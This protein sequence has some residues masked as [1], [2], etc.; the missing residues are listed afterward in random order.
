MTTLETYVR[1]RQGKIW[2]RKDIEYVLGRC[3]E[4]ADVAIRL[5]RAN[6]IVSHE[7]D[8]QPTANPD[9]AAGHAYQEKP[10][11]VNLPLTSGQSAGSCPP[12]SPAR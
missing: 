8:A 6:G 4:I 11:R 12:D 7:M 1:S 9:R 5:M 2:R 10:R 3:D